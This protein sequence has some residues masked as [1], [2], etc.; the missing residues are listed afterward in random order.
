MCNNCI[1][2]RCLSGKFKDINFVVTNSQKLHSVPRFLQNYSISFG[3]R[4]QLILFYF[5]AVW[6]YVKGVK[7]VIRIH[8]AMHIYTRIE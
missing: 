5:C 8:I 3:K 2:Q 7:F 6:H 4:F 1:N